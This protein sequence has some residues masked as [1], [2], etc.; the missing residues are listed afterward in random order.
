MKILVIADEES[1]SLWDYFSPAK[2]EGIDMIISC[3]DLKANY[4]Q[5]LVTFG[6]CPLLYVRGN[7]DTGY[8]V[9]GIR[10]N[11]FKAI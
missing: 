4:L 2:L 7:H 5:F 3:G 1:R 8:R 6:N 11:R 10:K 9:S